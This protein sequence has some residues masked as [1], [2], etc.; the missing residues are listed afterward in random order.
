VKEAFGLALL[1]AQA[2]GVPVVAGRS[3][4]VASIVKDNTTGLLSREGDYVEFG[5]AVAT[6]LDDPSRRQAMAKAAADSAE[7]EHDI[8][9]AAKTVDGYLRLLV[10]Q[11]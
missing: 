7:R 4:G 5:N 3:G 9:R 1:E 11:Q 2:A 8:T 10:R 6:L